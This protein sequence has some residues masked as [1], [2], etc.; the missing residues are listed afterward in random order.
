MNHS[1]SNK[2][3]K[4]QLSN[5]RVSILEPSTSVLFSMYDKIS[6]ENRTTQYR[7]PL[8]GNWE[9]S[10]L[11]KV[12]F[13]AGN[14]QILQ[15]TIRAEVFRIS[16]G[17]YVISP[18]DEDKLKI[19]MRSTFLQYSANMKDKIQ[20]Q[21]TELNKIITEYSVKQIYGEAQSYLKYLQ[22]ASTMYTPMDRPIQPN[23]PAK[24][25]DISRHIGM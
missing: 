5:G 22:D 9:E 1:N 10:T 4:D 2:K 8:I 12:F 11:S 24:S 17:V 18:Q 21:I 20:K 25:L 3:T 15:N 19:I 23:P 7:D 13:S 6:L 14:I 16:K